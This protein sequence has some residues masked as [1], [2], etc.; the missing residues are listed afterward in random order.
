MHRKH[1][2]FLALALMIAGCGGGE[3][4][5]TTADSASTTTES[6][7]ATTTSSTDAADASDQTTTTVVAT[8]TT[9]MVETTTTAIP[10]T[11]TSTAA[12]PS[13]LPSSFVAITSDYEAVEVDTA[14]GQIIH[15]FGQEA[16]AAEIDSAEEMPPNAL[17]GIWRLGDGSMVGIS[18]CCEPAAGNLLY[19]K[20]DGNLSNGSEPAFASAYGWT[21][22]AS[23]TANMFADLG[24]TLVVFDPSVTYDTGPGWDLVDVDFGLSE[25]TVAWARD[26]SELFWLA[27][28]DD[29]TRLITLDLAEGSPTYVADLDW[30]GS[31]QRLDGIGSQASGNLVGFLQTLD[32]SYNVVE[33]HG[34]VFSTS[35]EM[36]A[37]FA[38]ETGALWG[39]YDQTGV[40]LIYVDPSGTVRW[41]GAGDSAALAKGFVFA[42]W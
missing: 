28:K 16:S 19:L 36:L 13:D 29:S 11:T 6:A 3:A 20:A 30:V 22:S 9:A 41:Q 21:L 40:Y 26:G 25:G 27:T 18:D 7:A 10:T 42:S 33:T 12:G 1:L 31:N 17:Y 34:I 5:E 32:D 2:L 39:G 35:G 14:T 8:T 23:P 15:V 37:E 4:V 24:Y 38:V